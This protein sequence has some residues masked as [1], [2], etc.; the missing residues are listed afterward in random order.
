MFQKS[1]VPMMQRGTSQC[2]AAMLRDVG[3]LSSELNDFHLTR[4]GHRPLVEHAD[5]GLR[6]FHEIDLIQLCLRI[7]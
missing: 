6:S 3:Y 7:S 4:A 2:I 5:L 1:R